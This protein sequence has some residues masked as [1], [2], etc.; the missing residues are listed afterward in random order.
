MKNLIT[1]VISIFFAI[2]LLSSCH[3]HEGF[4]GSSNIVSSEGLKTSHKVIMLGKCEYIMYDTGVG[5]AGHGFLAHKGDCK[6]AIH[7]HNK[8]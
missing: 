1:I 5:Y 2:L 6:N 3:E 4:G 8:K 7:C